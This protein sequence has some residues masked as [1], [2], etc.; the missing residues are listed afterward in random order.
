MVKLYLRSTIRLQ[1]VMFNELSTGTTYLQCESSPPLSNY[2]HQVMGT[3]IWNHLG[4]DERHGSYNCE[5]KTSECS[6][7]T[8]LISYIVNVAGDRLLIGRK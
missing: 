4:Y 5:P 1:S 8:P 2:R 3:S 6:P 7:S